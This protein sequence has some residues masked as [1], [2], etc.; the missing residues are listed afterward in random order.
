MPG[1]ECYLRFSCRRRKTRIR[2][3][4]ATGRERHKTQEN[5]LIQER[6]ISCP[7]SVNFWRTFRD[8]PDFPKEGVLF[9]DITPMLQN[10]KAFQSGGGHGGGAL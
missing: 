5:L 9:K 1:I 8:V 10:A 2:D 7:R 3:G 4:G 6:Y